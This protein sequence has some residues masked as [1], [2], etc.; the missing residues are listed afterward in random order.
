MWDKNVSEWEQLHVGLESPSS[1]QTRYAILF[2]I[3]MSCTSLQP[4]MYMVEKM[5]SFAMSL[6]LT[7]PSFYCFTRGKRTPMPKGSS[8][9]QGSIHISGSDERQ[10]MIIGHVPIYTVIWCFYNKVGQ[11]SVELHGSYAAQ[12]Q[13]ICSLSCNKRV[14]NEDQ[15]NLA[16]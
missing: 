8:S 15:V 14:M 16:K 2:T 11:F 3:S 6:L 4:N 9:L 10:R 1:S 5:F 13:L 12:P 7:I